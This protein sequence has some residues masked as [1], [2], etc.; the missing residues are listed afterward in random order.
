MPRTC[1]TMTLH[2]A[3][4]GT[5]P[6]Y[7]EN[8]RRIEAFTTTLRRSDAARR[9]WIVLMVSSRS[10]SVMFS[11]RRLRVRDVRRRRGL[12]SAGGG[13]LQ[14]DRKIVSMKLRALV[15]GAALATRELWP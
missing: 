12:R 15:E 8:H 7:R 13:R 14:V 2:N 10:T 9:I 11:A 4:A 3:L 6:G 1:A 5:N